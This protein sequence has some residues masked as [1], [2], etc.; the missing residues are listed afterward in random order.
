MGKLLS[1]I[2]AARL[3]GVDRKKVRR[4]TT[5]GIIPVFRDPD[6][7]RP[8]YPEEALTDWRRSFFDAT[9]KAS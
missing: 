7:D 2:A 6:S 4:W 3:L 8:L 1:Q 5:L 9:K